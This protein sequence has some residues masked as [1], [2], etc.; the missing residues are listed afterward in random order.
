MWLDPK[1]PLWANRCHMAVLP[2]HIDTL[3]FGEKQLAFRPRWNP[4]SN[5]R[6]LEF[7]TPL[8][9]GG[10]GVGGFEL[11]AHVSKEHVSRDAMMQL[12][13][14]P[15]GQKRVELWRCCWKPIH[16]HT[17]RRWGP[18]GLEFARF[19]KVNH[20]HA[21]ADNW[22]EADGRMRSG[23][24]PAARLINPDPPTLSEFIAFCGECFRISNI[25]LI[26]V[27]SRNVDMFWTPV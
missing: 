11:R 24:L 16:V 7:T 10:V 2:D 14:A 21:F 18:P 20:H 27:P 8:T 9:S 4:D 5:P 19:E 6:F 12:E 15:A 22:V 13:Y 26:E 1:R 25:D 3:V 23:S 17:N